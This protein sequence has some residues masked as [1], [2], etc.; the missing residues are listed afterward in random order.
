LWDLII[1]PLIQ[2]LPLKKNGFLFHFLREVKN[3]LKSGKINK[4]KFYCWGESQNFILGLAALREEGIL[5]SYLQ[6]TR[7]IPT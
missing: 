7:A 2:N 1:L 5:A 3:K 4:T 6:N